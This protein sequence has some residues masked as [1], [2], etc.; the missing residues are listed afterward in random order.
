MS[1]YRGDRRHWSFCCRSVARVPYLLPWPWPCA[2]SAD[3]ALV[4]DLLL[5]LFLPQGSVVP[6]VAKRETVILWAALNVLS[7][8]LFGAQC[9]CEARN[10]ATE[11]FNLRLFWVSYDL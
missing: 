10:G 4:R 11:A 1:R 5:S 8:A 6:G 3:L 2:R 9:L 7:L